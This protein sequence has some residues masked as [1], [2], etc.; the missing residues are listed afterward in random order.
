ML[1]TLN[2]YYP[3]DTENYLHTSRNLKTTCHKDTVGWISHFHCRPTEQT[4]I[5][6]LCFLLGN[7]LLKYIHC[8]IG[9]FEIEVL[10]LIEIWKLSVSEESECI[11]LVFIV[12]NTSRIWQF[13][14]SGRWRHYLLCKPN[15]TYTYKNANGNNRHQVQIA[16]WLFVYVV[17]FLIL[18]DYI[19]FFWINPSGRTVALC[20][21]Q[22][23]TEMTTLR[24]S[25]GR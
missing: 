4:Q 21:T 11:S 14:I 5:E 1:C 24:I 16:T 15:V 20:L 18:S 7:A 23:L 22:P 13:F 2:I 10:M 19:G 8:L 12:I 17:T 6:S 9:C 3:F 25:W